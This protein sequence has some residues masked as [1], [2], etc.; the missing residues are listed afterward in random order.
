[1]STKF[2]YSSII[3][4]YIATV[5]SGTSTKNTAPPPRATFG[6]TEAF[7]TSSNFTALSK[8]VLIRLDFPPFHFLTVM[9][10]I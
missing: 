4:Q 7:S 2:P 9:G 3:P 8:L 10:S 1:M 6:F 5:E